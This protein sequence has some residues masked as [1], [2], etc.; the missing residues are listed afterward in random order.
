MS[1]GRPVSSIENSRF[2]NRT[3][4]GLRASTSNDHFPAGD[5]NAEAVQGTASHDF[6]DFKYELL[7]QHVSTI[8]TGT[9]HCL[10]AA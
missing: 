8:P 4:G 9:A 2:K 7:F 1:L 5:S 10:S 3:R 6:S